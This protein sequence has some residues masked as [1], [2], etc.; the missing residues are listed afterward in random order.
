MTDLFQTSWPSL[1]A[2][3]ALGFIVAAI[4]GSG[5]GSVG[6]RTWFWRTALA[7][8]LA[9][10]VLSWTGLVEGRP[11]L[12]LDIAAPVVAAYTIGCLA[13]AAIRRLVAAGRPEAAGSPGG[14]APPSVD[15]GGPA[16]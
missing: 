13:G 10:L 15:A 2:A 3:A 9:G 1:A 14:A 5:R 6:N 11:G 8:A 7:A 4:G 16:A 12:W